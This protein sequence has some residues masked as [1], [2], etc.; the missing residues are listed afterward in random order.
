MKEF[1]DIAV[2]VDPEYYTEVQSHKNEL[3]QLLQY[4]AHLAIYADEKA[5]KGT[6]YVETAFG[7]I[8]AGIDT[9]LQQ[10]KQKL[11]SLLETA[12]VVQ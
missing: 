11:L 2:Y 4:G 6:C 10:L 1:D 3:E 9:Q 7:R 12:G 8:D 5:S